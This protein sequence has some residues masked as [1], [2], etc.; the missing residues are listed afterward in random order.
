MYVICYRH[1][2]SMKWLWYRSFHAD[3]AN[4]QLAASEQY[5]VIR[6]TAS[7]SQ[8]GFCWTGHHSMKLSSFKH[9]IGGTGGPLRIQSMQVNFSVVSPRLIVFTRLMRGISIMISLFNI[10]LRVLNKAK[11]LHFSNPHPMSRQC[12]R[13]RLY[14]G[15]NGWT[16]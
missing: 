5:D 8:N 11:L 10:S 3:R 13:T 2:L 6:S 15:L 14:L 12:W 7:F 1:I 9:I 4:L 16:C